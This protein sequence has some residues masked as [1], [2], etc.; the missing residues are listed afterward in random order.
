MSLL[1]SSQN[2]TGYIQT[3]GFSPCTL[4]PDLLPPKPLADLLTIYSHV[5]I[6]TTLSP[7]DLI[8]TSPCYSLNLY[9]EKTISTLK[10]KYCTQLHTESSIPTCPPAAISD[11]QTEPCTDNLGFFLARYISEGRVF[12]MI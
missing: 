6:K 7:Q 8:Y 11:T 3:G 2:S 5:T 10:K 12:S 4:F 9:T 1:N